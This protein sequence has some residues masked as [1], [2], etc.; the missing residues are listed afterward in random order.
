MVER[1]SLDQ[2]DMSNDSSVCLS[3]ASPCLI[4]ALLLSEIRRRRASHFSLESTNSSDGQ[5]H[6]QQLGLGLCL[7]RIP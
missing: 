1:T 3:H 5:E 4:N 2:V 7:L 6:A